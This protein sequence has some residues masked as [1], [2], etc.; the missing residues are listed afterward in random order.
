MDYVTNHDMITMTMSIFKTLIN[1]NNLLLGGS[2]TKS[3]G[4][5]RGIVGVKVFALFWISF[6]LFFPNYRKSSFIWIITI[7]VTEYSVYFI[8]H[9]VH[10]VSNVDATG[11]KPRF[12]FE[13]HAEDLPSLRQ[14]VKVHVLYRKRQ[15][16]RWKIFWVT[17]MECSL[18]K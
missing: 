10:V 5:M 7:L 15:K 16:S 9:N 18:A 11:I 2:I 8:E 14:D 17:C 6:R 12:I 13:G 1:N 3:G 4:R